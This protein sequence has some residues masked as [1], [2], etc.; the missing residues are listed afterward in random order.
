M[1]VN[2]ISPTTNGNRYTV[3][4]KENINVPKN[5]QV[6][7]NFCSLSR[8]SEVILEED[9]H[10]YIDVR[11]DGSQLPQV[12]PQLV[13]GNGNN[14]FHNMAGTHTKIAKGQY[15]YS[16]LLNTISDQLYAQI[17]N[18]STYGKLSSYRAITSEDFFNPDGIIPNDTDFSL[19]LIWDEDATEGTLNVKE[20]TLS[21]IHGR[22]GTN[23]NPTTTDAENGLYIKSSATDSST[24]G[25]KNFDNYGLSNECYFHYGTNDEGTPIIH[26]NICEFKSFETIDELRASQNSLVIGLYS[27]SYA[28]GLQGTDGSPAPANDPL[29]RTRGLLQYNNVGG[30]NYNNPKQNPASYTNDLVNRK[31]LG[32]F[33]QIQLDY[34]VAPTGR[35]SVQAL[36]KGNTSAEQIQNWDSQNNQPALMENRGGYIQNIAGKLN[37]SNDDHIHLG[38]QTYYDK[39]SSSSYNHRVGRRLYFRVINMAKADVSKSIEQQVENILVYDSKAHNLYFNE[40]FFVEDTIVNPTVGTDAVKTNKI[41]SQ[42]PFNVCCSS[43]VQNTGFTDIRIPTL[44]DTDFETRPE[45]IITR[46]RIHATQELGQYLGLSK[47]KTENGKNTPYYS[48]WLYPNHYNALNPNLVHLKTIDL[49]WR[50]ESYSISINNLPIRNFKNTES[51]RDGGFSKAIISNIPTPFSQSTDFVSQ[52]QHLTSATYSPNYQIISNLY[53]QELITN[54]FDVEIRRL[55]DDLPA[56]EILKSIVNFTIVPPP[57]YTKNINAN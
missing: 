37:I 16:K 38:F 24:M 27:A 13:G 55:K 10:I 17:A 40:N 19:G 23:I 12:L 35:F 52:E 6:Y 15:S 2:L 3:R 1:N 7:L 34:R 53:N 11:N 42:I 4:F 33:I 56:T 39:T 14:P 49:E 50:N 48:N 28:N 31:F 43:L 47:F 41:R 8:E 26:Q 51:T 22:N 25:Y 5:S 32:N 29:T 21:A 30:V 18:T 57:S 20:A 46:Y 36:R 54:K 9:Q 44:D 45:S